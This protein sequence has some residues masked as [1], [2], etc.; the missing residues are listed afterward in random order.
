[1]QSQSYIG[2]LEKAT[3]GPLTELMASLN[4]KGFR[5]IPDAPEII[6]PAPPIFG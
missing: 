3:N 1:M 6:F 2:G 5:A 4:H